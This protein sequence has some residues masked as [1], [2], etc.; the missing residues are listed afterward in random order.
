MPLRQRIWNARLL[1]GVIILGFIEIVNSYSR[2]FKGHDLIGLYA[3]YTGLFL[4]FSFPIIGIIVGGRRTLW[5]VYLAASLAVFMKTGMANLMYAVYI[6]LMLL[7]A[8]QL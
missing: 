7:V 2:F 5:S 8:H 3:N 4:D 1:S 6:G